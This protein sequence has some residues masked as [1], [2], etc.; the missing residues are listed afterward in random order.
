MGRASAP[1]ASFVVFEAMARLLG[2]SVSR[3]A[4]YES[5]HDSGRRWDNI[6]HLVPSSQNPAGQAE[7][8]CWSRVDENGSPAGRF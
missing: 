6:A 2:E 5:R 4:T 7:V 1:A 8:Q 3:E